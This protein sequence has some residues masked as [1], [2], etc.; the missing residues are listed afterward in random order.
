VPFSGTSRPGAFV[1]I[2]TCQLEFSCC[3]KTWQALCQ[4]TSV[5]G[6]RFE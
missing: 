3:K 4:I 2:G 5:F 1:D 6:K